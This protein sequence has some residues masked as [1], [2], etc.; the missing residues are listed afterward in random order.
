[1]TPTRPADAYTLT[2]AIVLVVAPERFGRNRLAAEPPAA[3]L[4]D[5]PARARSLDR[6]P[7]RLRALPCWRWRQRVLEPNSK[8]RKQEQLAEEAPRQD[9][10]AVRRRSPPTTREHARTVRSVSLAACG[11]RLAAHTSSLNLFRLLVPALAIADAVA[12]LP[13]AGLWLALHA[14]PQALQPSPHTRA[15]V[16]G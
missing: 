4:P 13:H 12:Q 1:M 2:R 14:L 7:V 3:A 6:P 16:I 11:R 9:L 8:R 10:H 15:L 5:Q